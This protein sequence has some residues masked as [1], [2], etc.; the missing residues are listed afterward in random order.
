MFFNRSKSSRENLSLIAW[1]TLCLICGVPGSGS[2]P[3]SI[4]WSSDRGVQSVRA[5]PVLIADDGWPN[6]APTSV[7]YRVEEALGLN[8][9]LSSYESSKIESHYWKRAGRAEMIN[10]LHNRFFFLSHLFKYC[11]VVRKAALKNFVLRRIKRR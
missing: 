1:A 3:S 9:D 8:G 10:T 7:A 4:S 2:Q 5:R 6:P 11:P